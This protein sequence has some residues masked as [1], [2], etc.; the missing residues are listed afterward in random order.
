MADVRT[1]RLFV[2]SPGDVDQERQRVDLLAQRLSAE[3][4][5]AVQF[6]TIRWET[7]YY[8]A[9]STFQSQIPEASQCDIVVAI[10]WSRLGTELPSGFSTMPNG[11]PYPSGSAYEVLSAIH[12]RATQETPDVYVFKKTAEPLI[13]L[14]DSKKLEVARDQWDRLAAFF[15]SWFV[16]PTGEFSAAFHTFD[17]TDQFEQH[18]ERLLRAWIDENVFGGE[19]VLAWPIELKGSPFCGLAPFEATHAPVFFGR[20]R[21]VTRAIERIE[22][23]ASVGVPFLLIVG[24]S[25]VGKSSFVRAGVVP[26]LTGPGVVRGVD[27]WRVAILRPGTKPIESVAHAVFGNASSSA[28]IGVV[29]LPEIAQGDCGT[30]QKLAE[31]LRAGTPAAVDVILNALRRVGEQERERRG[32]ERDVACHLLLVIDQFD[33]LFA[34]EMEADRTALAE[35]LTKLVETRRV[36]IIGT[37]RADLYEQYVADPALLALKRDGASYDL[38]PPGP[39]ELAEIV[40][41]PAEVSGLVYERSARTGLTLDEMLLDDAGSGDV[42]PLIEFT[43]QQLFGMRQAIDGKQCLTIASYEALGALDGAIERTGEDALE[44]IDATGTDAL[45]ELFRHLVGTTHSDD[46]MGTARSQ[47]AIRPAPLSDFPAGSEVRRIVDALVAARLLTTSEEGGV[48]AVRL[49]HQR[50]LQAWSRARAAVA[51]N[52]DYYRVIGEIR[53]QCRRWQD[54]GG[55]PSLLLPKDLLS[56]VRGHARRFGNFDRLLTEFIAASRWRQYMFRLGLVAAV[57]PLMVAFEAAFSGVM[58]S[59]GWFD[60]NLWFDDHVLFPSFIFVASIL[61]LSPIALGTILL[62]YGASQRSCVGHLRS[63]AS[64]AQPRDASFLPAVRSRLRVLFSNAVALLLIGGVVVVRIGLLVAQN[65]NL[66]ESPYDLYDTIDKVIVSLL[67]VWLVG[68]LSWLAL[69]MT[70][71]KTTDGAGP[72]LECA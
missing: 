12:A 25:G 30:W 4:G 38:A 47:L 37:L 66:I 71:R 61:T 46:A 39:A 31:L 7:S 21:D 48:P 20:S 19:R 51:A 59:S 33:D 62:R 54:S 55:K 3:Y 11:E 27:L 10:F 17:T 43:L 16:T 42:L 8:K 72:H 65:F 52:A 26:R 40:R 34:A 67:G 24:A 70:R 15:R 50:L 49:A 63:Q 60:A 36:W 9:H 64:S 18:C 45:A 68:N 56:E 35:F 32:H 1:V 6:K 57:A 44:S 58:K 53:Q 29:G 22:R 28:E 2:S 5:A 13:S 14:S 23:A 69:S 41:R